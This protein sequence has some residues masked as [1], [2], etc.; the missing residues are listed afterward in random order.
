[1]VWCG[2]VGLIDGNGHS[3]TTVPTSLTDDDL[4]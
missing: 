4:C 1:M 2:P 3:I